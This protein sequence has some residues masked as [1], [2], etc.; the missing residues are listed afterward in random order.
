MLPLHSEARAQYDK[1]QD[2]FKASANKGLL[3]ARFYDGY[4]KAFQKDAQ[5]D[6][7]ALRSLVGKCGVQQ[8]IKQAA[9]RLHALI[10]RLEGEFGVFS[11]DWH[12]VT[13]MGNSHP[14]ESGVRCHSTLGTLYFQGVAVTCLLRA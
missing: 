8:E 6:T 14:A 12:V 2:K 5:A 7:N 11:T 1:Q 10:S 9:S 13:S 4:D 3:F